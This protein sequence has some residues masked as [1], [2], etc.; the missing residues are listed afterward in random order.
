M[1][2]LSPAAI[3]VL[4]FDVFGAVVD[5]RSGVIAEGQQLGKSKGLD[6]D[7]AA[8]ADAWRGVYRPNLN[9]VLSGELPWT[10]LDD[11]HGASLEEMLRRFKIEG[12]SGEEINDF[13]RVWHRLSSP[14]IFWT[15]RTSSMPK[16][17][18]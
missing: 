10:R 7:W 16:F 11:L 4:A 17:T 14:R 18:A 3:R 8:F 1:A 9:R 13:S 5:W 15:S 12:L 2:T 6:V